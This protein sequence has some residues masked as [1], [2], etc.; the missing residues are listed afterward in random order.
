M[1]KNTIDPNIRKIEKNEWLLV[2][3]SIL[4]F[5][6]ITTPKYAKFPSNQKLPPFTS[7]G[8]KAIQNISTEES[9]A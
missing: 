9:V 1:K 3:I 4:T 7:N 6:T 8:K 2:A 5:A